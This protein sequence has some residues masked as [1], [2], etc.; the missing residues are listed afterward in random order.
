[1]KSHT[2]LN[3]T[4]TPSRNRLPRKDSL[5]KS[6]GSQD[7]SI[8]SAQLNYNDPFNM[9][10]KSIPGKLGK[11]ILDTFNGPKIRREREHYN[12]TDSEEEQMNKNVNE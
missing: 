1:M 9:M 6:F 8:E 5:F 4:L 3:Q 12:E 2:D 7:Q 10:S 11:T